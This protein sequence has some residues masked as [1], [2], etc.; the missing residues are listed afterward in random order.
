MSYTTAA[1]VRVLLPGLLTD[2]DDLGTIASG[3]GITLTYPAYAVPSIAINGVDSTAFTFLRPDKITLTSA[4]TGQRYIASVSKGLNDTDLESLIAA[5]DR[6]LDAAFANFDMPSG[7]Y[8]GDWS[9]LLTAARYLRL[10]ATGTGENI[11][12]AES[13]EQI[14][15]DAINS[16]KKDSSNDTEN[17]IVKVNR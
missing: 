9:E 6:V 15:T 5:S 17:I 3:T 12:K 7:S 10:Y 4:A 1:K 8:L 16:F 13:M 14:V 11:E 2:D